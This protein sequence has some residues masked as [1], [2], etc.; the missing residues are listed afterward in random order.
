MKKLL[1]LILALTLL[2]AAAL[3]F[4]S[5]EL[6]RTDNVTI[7]EHP[8]SADTVIRLLNQPYL[9]ELDDGSL[10]VFIDYLEDATLDLTLLRVMAS[11]TVYAP[12]QADTVSFTVGK[13]TYAFAADCTQ[14][15]YDGLYMEDY[16]FC[17]TAESLAFL[18][19]LAQ[20]KKDDPITVTFSYL[21]E[22]QMTGRV[23]LP[24]D[25]CARLYDRY[26]DLGGKRQDLGGLEERW[27]C[28]IEK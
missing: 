17:L 5:E 11:I 23:V 7:F 9:G 24:G 10:V 18:K 16:S 27:P 20:Q 8:G 2:P 21:G 15:E 12:M 6:Y 13:K 1:A 4:D 26:I 3:A 19:A 14:N 25:D 22:T 28:K